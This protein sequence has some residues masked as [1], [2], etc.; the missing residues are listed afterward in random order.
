MAYDDKMSIQERDKYLRKMQK[1]YRKAD[2]HTRGKLLDEMQTVTE[3]HRKSLIRLM[4]S[5]IRRKPRVG[6]RG[7]TYGPQIEYALRVISESL[8]HICAERLKPNLVWMAHHLSQHGELE[9]SSPLLDKLQKISVSTV[10][11]LLEKAPRDR[12]RL[13]RK[14]PERANRLAREIPARRIPWQ[15]QEPGHLETDLVHHCGVSASG[16][17]V[18]TLQMID[19]ATGWSE[20]AAALGRSHLV[21]RDA[22]QRFLV[23]LPFPVLEVHPDNGSEFL[24]YHLRRFW[25]EAA[26]NIELSR[27]RAWQKND[28]RFVEQKNDT[29]VRAYLGY[30]RLDT[31]EQTNLLNQLYDLMWLYYNF[32]QPVMRLKEKTVVP[33]PGRHA[34]IKRRFDDARTPFD[35]LCATGVLDEDRKMEL[36]ALRRGTNPRKLREE[37]YALIDQIFL[38]PN[39]AQGSNQD[40][41]LTLF[42]V[43]ETKKELAIPVTLSN[44]RTITVR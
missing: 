34:R 41:Y 9:I 26:D 30:D 31:V 38:L 39:A 13:P 36:E 28:N 4:G 25:K 42:Q 43:P 19:V 11:R 29:L 18:H 33:Q 23:R 24:N 44:D 40:V 5:S 16:H 6:R 3:L 14:G 27:S 32:F 22:F 2:R 8:D 7:P 10:R 20:R 37:I 17:Y 15:E 12:P 21:I 35:R 1:R